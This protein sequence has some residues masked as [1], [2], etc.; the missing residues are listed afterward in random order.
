MNALSPDLYEDLIGKPYLLHARGPDYLDCVGLLLAIC[1]RRGLE[2]RELKSIPSQVDQIDDEW[3]KVSNP[4][5]GD[6]LLFRSRSQVWHVGVAIDDRLMIHAS[7]DEGVVVIERYDSRAHAR[8]FHCAY[9]CKLSCAQLPR[10][11]APAQF[12]AFESRL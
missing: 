7:E 1:R 6:A 11:H 12:A 3:E 5:P 4:G 10:R 8:R 9:R 2:V